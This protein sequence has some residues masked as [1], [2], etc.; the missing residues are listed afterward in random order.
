MRQRKEN[1]EIMCRSAG[2]FGAVSGWLRPMALLI[3]CSSCVEAQ[4]SQAKELLARALRLADLY[5]WADAAPA[6][7]EAEQLF[8]RAGDQRNALYARL[9]RIRSNIEREQGTLPMCLRS[10]QKRWRTILFFRTIRSSACSA[11]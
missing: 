9:G 3:V 10:L 8:T 1:R 2:V 5:N 6:F 4:Q 7:A 11:S